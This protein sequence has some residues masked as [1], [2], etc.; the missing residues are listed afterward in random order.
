MLLIEDNRILRDG[1]LVMLK[2][3]QD[4]DAVAV[5]GKR[6][7]TVVKIHRLKPNVILLDLGLRSLNSLHVVESAGRKFRGTNAIVMDL[8]TVPADIM[9]FAGTPQRSGDGLVRRTGSVKKVAA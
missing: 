4:I 1:I 9:Q 6:A 7:N 8:A 5:S 2:K 3:E